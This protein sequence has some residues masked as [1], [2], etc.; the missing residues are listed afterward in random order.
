[1]FFIVFASLKI[2]KKYKIKKTFAHKPGKSGYNGT[3]V[4]YFKK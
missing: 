2:N 3:K 4:H 1:M